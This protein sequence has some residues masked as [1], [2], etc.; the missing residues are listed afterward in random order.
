MEYRNAPEILSFPVGLFDVN[1]YL[2][3]PKQ[4]GVLYIIDPGG[5]PE[6]ILKQVQD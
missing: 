6:K 2:V 5:D 3:Y 4:N 1:C